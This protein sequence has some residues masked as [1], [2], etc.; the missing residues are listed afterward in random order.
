[1]TKYGRPSS[2]PA[3]SV[4]TQCYAVVR[5]KLAGNHKFLCVTVA[6]ISRAF[7]GACSLRPIAIDVRL[8]AVGYSTMTADVSV[9]ILIHGS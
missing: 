8:V 2:S 9:V 7:F 3:A 4:A 5:I 1:M 6:H